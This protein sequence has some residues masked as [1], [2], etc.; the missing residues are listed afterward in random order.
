[1]A[2][3]P[4]ILNSSILIVDDRET[5]VAVMESMLRGGGYVSVSS[6]TNPLEVCDLHRRHRYDLILL[7]LKMPE[8]DGFQ[9]MEALKEIEK[10]ETTAKP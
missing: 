9:V 6:T 5:D 3:S 2:F 1:M 10:M 4:D 7:D 8:M